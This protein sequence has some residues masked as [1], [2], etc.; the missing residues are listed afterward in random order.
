MLDNI[1][2]QIGQNIG[3]FTIESIEKGEGIYTLRCKCGNTS[4]GGADHITKKIS[5]L[6]AN[7]YTA[8]QKCTYRIKAELDRAK[9]KDA[10]I[11]TYG[12]VYREYVAKA[13][14]RKIEFNL[15]LEDAYNL[16]KSNCY[17]CDSPPSNI[18]VRS[19]GV[20][21]KYQGIDRVNNDIGYEKE[22]VVP[23]C[24]YCNS[25]KMDR[26][27]ESFLENVCKI[28]N[29]K[30]QRLDSKESYTQ[31]SGNGKHPT[32]EGEDIV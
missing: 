16:F 2:Y 25:F 20:E 10:K 8:C 9:L 18:R 1:H 14:D 28:Y 24:K 12:D 5:L 32:T 15:S 13:K 31:A 4:K 6:L 22:N 11:Y 21:V 17:Y 3:D 7:G 26:T 29:N 27:V 30:V 23:C 19:T